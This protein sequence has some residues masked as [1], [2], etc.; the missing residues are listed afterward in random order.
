MKSG[1]DVIDLDSARLQVPEASRITGPFFPS[2][3]VGFFVKKSSLGFSRL[4]RDTSSLGQVSW[5]RQ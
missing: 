1:E 5:W 2:E 3:R 4:V